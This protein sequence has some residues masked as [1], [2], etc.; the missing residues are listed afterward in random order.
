MHAYGYTV[1][2]PSDESEE[3][4]V[5]AL[6]S[7]CREK[8]IELEM[9]FVDDYQSSFEPFTERPAA[10]KLIELV[11]VRPVNY[12]VVY[13]LGR[14]GITPLDTL[15]VV[16]NVIEKPRERQGLGLEVLSVREDFMNLADPNERDKLIRVINWFSEQERR[17]IRERQEVA[18]KQGKQ[19]GRPREVEPEELL[20]YIK[21]Y[22]GLSM[23]AIARIMNEDRERAGKRRLGYS[24]V[25]MLAKRL[26]VRWRL[27]IP[28]QIINDGDEEV[29]KD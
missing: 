20:D 29:R 9:V 14:L 8:R 17:R 22:P 28:Q 19:K 7:F 10:C 21:R 5:K 24:T 25:R 2:N 27:M 4:Q 1:L 3:E 11:K 26:G 12:L 6:N 16:L 13:E 15:N 23:S 18:W